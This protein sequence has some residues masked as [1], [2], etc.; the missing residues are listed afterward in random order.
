[1]SMSHP[2]QRPLRTAV[3]F[4]L[5]T[6]L[7][8]P[9]GC[10]E[11]KPAEPAPAQASPR[12]K[13]VAF[14]Y[15]VIFN[16]NSVVPAV[17]KAFPGR[18]AEFTKAWRG[19]QFEYG[20]LRSIVNKHADFFKVTEDALVYTAQAMKLDLTPEKRASL[21]DAYLNLEPWPDAAES[22]RKLRAAGV[23]IITIANFSP[24]M[25]KANADHAKITDLFDELLSTEVNGTYKPDPKA[26]ALGMEHLKLKK[27]EIVF[28]AF[29]G[30]DAYGAKSFGYTTYWVNR[31]HL[32]PEELD[33]KPDATSND[34]AGLVKFVLGTP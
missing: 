32:P 10:S 15:F 21:M 27:D 1:M 2:I 14:D 5:L 24:K 28:A 18:G 25:L 12:F 11:K 33:A 34:M 6:A 26:Y 29:G 13:A 4:V 22:L 3:V 23:R 8:L 31:F 16:A 17:E 7:V 9:T 30:W 19:K 20:F